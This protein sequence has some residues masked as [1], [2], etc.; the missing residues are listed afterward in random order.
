MT[1]RNTFNPDDWEDVV[2]ADEKNMNDKKSNVAK[3]SLT[4]N[5][6][7]KSFMQT[8]EEEKVSTGATNHYVTITATVKPKKSINTRSVRL[9]D[10]YSE[11]RCL[12]E[13]DDEFD[14][15]LQGAR[16]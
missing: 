10:E 1:E 5:A 16:D 12:T 4:K 6:N 8:T 15:K 9:L 3:K 7:K 11:K 14:F 13:D 2:V